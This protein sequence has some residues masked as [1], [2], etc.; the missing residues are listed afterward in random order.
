MTD[1]STNPSSSSSTAG[2]PGALDIGD[3]VTV[4]NEGDQRIN[5]MFDS[6]PYRIDPGQSAP[7]PFEVAVLWLGDPR[8]AGAVMSSRDS[9]GL[10][11]FIPD[12]ATEVR[13]LKIKYGDPTGDE[14]NIDLT[15]SMHYPRVSVK[16]MDG[17]PI[18]FVLT[19]PTGEKSTPVP[20]STTHIDPASLLAIVERQQRQIDTLTTL[21]NGPRNDA[22]LEP[23]AGEDESV[24]GVD[25]VNGDEHDATG[26]S[27][28]TGMT[29]LPPD[30][31]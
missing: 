29:D 10:V 3:F 14:D 21:I 6:R 1:T 18:D 15:A 4:T 16:T 31:G 20:V 26:G 11:A 17:T 7:I 8:A 28:S 12:R 30:N 24:E 25:V 23:L 2:S 27:T 5:W 22:P 19:D 13:R 9:R